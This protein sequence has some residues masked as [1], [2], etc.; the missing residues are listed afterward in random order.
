M[1]FIPMKAENCNRPATGRYKGATMPNV[2]RVRMKSGAP[3]VDH[4]AARRF[5]VTHGVVGAGWGLNGSTQ[6]AEV[7]DGCRDL[8]KYLHHAKMVFPSNSAMLAAARIYGFHMK[9]GDYC[10]TYIPEAGEYWCCHVDSEFEYR[11]GGAF[12]LYDFH[13]TRR[14]IWANAGT[15]D[16]VPEV[17]TN[18]LRSQFGTVTAIIK[19]AHIA[20]EA[21]QAALKR[22][23]IQV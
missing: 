9:I 8:L 12:D 1:T 7:P 17:I 19:D 16:A 3:G 4:A 5:A 18:A 13:M 21:A 6:E 22:E 14:C 2:W 23:S 10:W 11:L 20:V 15:K